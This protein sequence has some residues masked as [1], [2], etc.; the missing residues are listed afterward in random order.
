VE[1]N[2]FLSQSIRYH[3]EGILFRLELDAFDVFNEFSHFF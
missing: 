1:V 2:N 3:A